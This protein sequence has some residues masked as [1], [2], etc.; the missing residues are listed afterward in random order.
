MTVEV[1]M[2]KRAC[3]D[4]AG[5]VRLGRG[6]HSARVALYS[7]SAGGRTCT[8]PHAHTLTCCAIGRRQGGNSPVAFRC[9]L[10]AR[11]ERSTRTP[12]HASARHATHGRHTTARTTRTHVPI[13][14]TAR[15][16]PPTT[17]PGPSLPSCSCLPRPCLPSPP[18]F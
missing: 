16:W 7:L 12:A 11:V 6:T 4:R 17:L 14:R 1:G 2:K 10:V 13:T 8:T 5:N 3:R 15:H 18:P 9:Q